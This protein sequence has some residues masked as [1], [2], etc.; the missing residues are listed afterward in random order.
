MNVAGRLPRAGALTPYLPLMPSPSLPIL[1]C[2]SVSPWGHLR[3]P[4]RHSLREPR[5]WPRVSSSLTQLGVRRR[6]SSEAG[7]RNH[8]APWVSR[9]GEGTQD[10]AAGRGSPWGQGPGL[11]A[12]ARGKEGEPGPPPPKPVS[13]SHS[14][15]PPPTSE[16]WDRRLKETAAPRGEEGSRLSCHHLAGTPEGARG[17]YGLAVQ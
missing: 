8:L 16:R 7:L 12:Q 6:S 1:L 5:Q 17:R 3:S 9:D 14:P 10:S 2:S 4:P 11:G 13:P 15:R